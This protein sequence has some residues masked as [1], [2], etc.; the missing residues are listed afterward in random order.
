MSS[1]YRLG[2]AGFGFGGRWAVGG[3][4]DA[5][6]TALWLILEYCG[7]QSQVSRMCDS[8]SHDTQA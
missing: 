6:K 5:G 1:R 8:W 7:A 2:K 3:E 4:D